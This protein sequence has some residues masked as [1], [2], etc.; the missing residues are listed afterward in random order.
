MVFSIERDH[1]KRGIQT[2]IVAGI[3]VAMVLLLSPIF[4]RWWHGPTETPTAPPPV[5]TVTGQTTIAELIRQTGLEL[6]TLRRALQVPPSTDSA[7]SLGA[8]GIA[9]AAAQT[10]LQRAL[11]LRTQEATKNWRKIASKFLLWGIWLTGVVFLLKRRR[12]TPRLRLRLLLLAVAVLVFGIMYGADQSP[13]GTVKDT[14]VLW[15]QHHL[16]FPPRLIALAVFLLLVILAHKSICGWGCQF[17]VLQDLL[18]HL[19]RDGKSRTGILPQVKLPFA[20]TNSIRILVVIVTTGLALIWGIDLIEPVNPFTIYNPTHLAI[21]GAVAVGVLLVASLFMYRPW[22][23]LACP[24][25]LLGWLVERFSRQRIRVD[26][27]ACVGCGA[28]ARACPSM[29]MQAI[30]HQERVRPDCFACGACVTTC[31]HQAITFDNQPQ[32]P[33]PDVTFAPKP[34][35]TAITPT[36]I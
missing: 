20:V 15:G 24:F 5:L 17:G 7:Q 22:C 11:A 35:A 18:F 14:L 32:M 16:L 34:A 23:H 36:D 1:M 33:I 29:A 8:L 4:A 12:I 3:I 31:P 10:R 2:V 9:P 28:C 19:N 26:Y 25:G 6:P 13:M 30:L 27:Q 21:T